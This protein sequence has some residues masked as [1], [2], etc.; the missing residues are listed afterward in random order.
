M[1]VVGTSGTAAANPVD[2]D[3]RP[4]VDFLANVPPDRRAI[5]I[6][7]AIKNKQLDPDKAPAVYKHFGLTPLVS[8]KKT[9]ALDVEADVANMLGLK[10]SA[11]DIAAQQ[12]QQ[13]QQEQPRK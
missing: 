1:P 8:A 2:P 9:T 13:E 7:T 10:G 6:E 4:I 5:Q 11:A 12:K 3:I